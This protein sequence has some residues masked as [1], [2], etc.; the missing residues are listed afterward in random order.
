MVVRHQPIPV[1][2]AAR[3]V[4]RLPTGGPD[5]IR[6]R[7]DADGHAGAV[8]IRVP[9]RPE[10]EEALKPVERWG[11]KW[12]SLVLWNKTKP[13]VFDTRS[14]AREHAEK[15]YGYIR[16]RKDLRGPPHNW[17]MPVPVR[18]LVSVTERRKP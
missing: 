18:V 9:P 17:R 3:A 16:T 13:L 2:E 14:E 15:R 8:G 1:N 12:W 5:R 4:P 6:M 7:L 11:L 10:E